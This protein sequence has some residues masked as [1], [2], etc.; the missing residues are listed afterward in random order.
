MKKALVIGFGISGQSA[1]RLLMRHGFAVTAADKNTNLPHPVGIELVSDTAPIAWE[2]LELAILSPGIPPTHPLARQV[3]EKG[4]ELIGEVELAFRYV[5]NRCVGITGSNGKTTTTL[6]TTHLLNAVGQKARAVGNVGQSMTAALEIADP[7]EVWVVE[8]SSFQLESL[9]T[10]K[11]EASVVLNI[12]PNHLDRYSSMEEYARAKGRI[13]E[14][15]RGSVAI[16][17]QVARDWGPL[18]SA[19]RFDLA[20]IRKLSYGLLERQNVEAAFWLC[21]QLGYPDVAEFVETF[22]RP[23]HRLEWVAEI[24]GVSYYN[25]SKATS[26]DAVLHALQFF[27][28]PGVLIAGGKDKGASYAPWIEPFREKVRQLVLYGEAAEKIE[29]EIGS[30]VP[31]IR[32]GAFDE[33]VRLSRKEAREKEFVLLSPGCSSYDQF[34]GFE[35]RGE[36]F[37]GM[38]MSWIEKKQS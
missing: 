32:V 16:S 20:P 9:Q 10:D 2:G 23:P 8:L 18:F 4:I 35:Q 13:Q 22:V 33:A 34:H 24:N 25:D 28:G 37:K 27:Q 38:V 17:E 15:T 29:R 30:A 3:V 7:N 12:T 21:S 31:S 14:C 6:L 26:V 36:A 19:T 11:L 5:R 1:A